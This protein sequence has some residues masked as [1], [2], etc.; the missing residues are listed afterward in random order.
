MGLNV[1]VNSQMA[2]G[3]LEFLERCRP[4]A[5]VTDHD[6]AH[7]SSCL[8]LAANTLGI[9][10]FTL[11][12][13]V[14]NDNA[15][16]YLPVIADWMFCWGEMHRQIM[17]EAGQDPATLVIGGCPRLTRDLPAEPSEVRS[18]LKIDPSQRVV[19]LGTSPVQPAQR[20]LLAAWFCEAVSG[21]NGVAGIV[22]LHP[23]EN[24]GFYSEIA[25]DYPQ[26][27][28]MDNAQVSLDEVAGR[29]GRGGSA[30]QRPGERLAGQS[31]VGRRGHNPA[32]SAGPWKGPDR[33]GR[34]PAG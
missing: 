21:L 10:T 23:S 15:V 6:R 14:M 3:S 27:T 9:P 7:L 18:R 11:Q 8:V 31:P 19:M 12:H 24:L 33:T 20:R 5:V 13:G 32:G 1:L 25:R 2:I 22:R 26:V 28:F 34:L 16:G 17:I 29:Y 30:K 4:A